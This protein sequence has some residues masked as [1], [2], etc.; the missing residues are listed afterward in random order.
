MVKFMNKTLAS[1]RHHIGGGGGGS[2]RLGCGGFLFDAPTAAARL[3]IR[4]LTAARAAGEAT[5]VPPNGDCATPEPR[6]AA[7]ADDEAA[8][9]AEAIACTRGGATGVAKSAPESAGK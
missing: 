9:S 1:S 3:A 8:F 2:G 6:A 5:G 7:T 4:F